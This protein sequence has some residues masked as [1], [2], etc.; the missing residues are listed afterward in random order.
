MSEESSSRSFKP[1]YCL[2][3]PKTQW[4]CSQLHCD[5]SSACLHSGLVSICTVWVANW[6]WLA[7]WFWRCFEFPSSSGCLIAILGSPSPAGLLE[8]RLVG[9]HAEEEQNVGSV[10]YV[11]LASTSGF[12]LCAN[13][14]I[15]AVVGKVIST[16]WDKLNNRAALK[17]GHFLKSSYYFLFHWRPHIGN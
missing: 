8:C 14:C 9:Q 3:T 15:L 16:P 13:S 10:F 6:T 2:I 1:F 17:Y 12:L 5:R 11:L 4:F 7:A